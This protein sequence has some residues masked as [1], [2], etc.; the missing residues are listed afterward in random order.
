MLFSCALILS[1]N[2]IKVTNSQC[3]TI[4]ATCNI[5]CDGNPYC[6]D[7]TII[8]PSFRDCLVECRYTSDRRL[9]IETSHH[10]PIVP[11]HIKPNQRNLLSTYSCTGNYGCCGSTIYCPA[12]HNCEISCTRGCNG[13]TI[14]A[15][16]SSNL[17]VKNCDQTDYENN[18]GNMEIYC[19][20]TGGDTSTKTCT[21]QSLYTSRQIENSNIYTQTGF[22]NLHFDTVQPSNTRV[23]CGKTGMEF[24]CLAA[25]KDACS[26]G[27]PTTCNNFILPTHEPTQLS[28]DSPSHTPTFITENPSQLPTKF[29]T[30][31]PSITPTKFPT[32]NPSITP[33]IFP[34]KIP[35]ITPTI[36]PSKIPSITPTI[37]PSKN[38]SITP[39]IFPTKI[40]SITPTTQLP[41]GNPTHEPT[42]H[43]HNITKTTRSSGQVLETIMSNLTIPPKSSIPTI[44]NN[45][46]WIII[47]FCIVTIVLII[48]FVLIR[49]YVRKRHKID[50]KNNYNEPL[51]GQTVG[52]ITNEH[53]NIP[54]DE[55]IENIDEIQNIN[56][57][58][59]K[60]YHNDNDI[61]HSIN[62]FNET[63]TAYT[64]R[65]DNN[66]TPHNPQSLSKEPNI[67]LVK[68]GNY[69]YF[70]GQKVLIEVQKLLQAEGTVIDIVD[71]EQFIMV[72][73]DNYKNGGTD[74]LHVIND[75]YRIKP[76]DMLSNKNV[77]K[78]V[79][80]NQQNDEQSIIKE[81]N[82]SECV[83]CMDKP[84]SYACI[85]CGHYAVCENCKDN[86]KQCPLCMA[87]C[88]VVRIYK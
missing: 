57:I 20:F 72:K 13:L 32:K 4:S 7:T 30:K 10:N 79:S 76:V 82:E 34:S 17:L 35:S 86:I 25:Q 68:Y 58:K 33:T 16:N 78:D 44:A 65:K 21:I 56:I 87:K 53:N 12:D 23:Y 22:N 36:F 18:C 3:S 74:K 5:N 77:E 75:G 19:P 11:I 80:D 41:N 81:K 31:I 84:P 69:N 85:P 1:V 52:N 48:V 14:Y 54:Y 46:L 29:P 28:T 50:E 64:T 71:N 73:Y 27:E 2:V 49:K 37:F 39:T 9:L 60:K 26:N 6:R 47:V 59:P 55:I 61:V 66:I 62:S 51:I 38:P 24:S 15:Q 42:F 63:E 8:C 88:T 45:K 67:E 43:I 40:P 70:I 83:I